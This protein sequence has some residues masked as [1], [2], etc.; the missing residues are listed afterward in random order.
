LETDTIEA[1]A[2]QLAGTLLESRRLAAPVT[3]ESGEIVH[4]IRGALMAHNLNDTVPHVQAVDFAAQFFVAPSATVAVTYGAATHVGNVRDNNEDHFAVIHRFRSQ[5]MLAT[6][7]PRENLHA[8]RDEAYAFVV[9]DGLGGAAGGE[10]ASRLVLE[11][12]WE[13]SAQASSWIMRFSDLSAQQVRKRLDAYA[14]RM[15]ERLIK[16]AESNP[17][18]EGMGTTWT[19]AYVTG[20]D[21]VLAQVG[22]SRAYLLRDGNLRQLTRDHTL[23]QELVD[24]GVDR[25]K[26]ERFRNVVTNTFGGKTTETRV[27]VDHVKLQNGD[28][29]LL[30]TDGLTELVAETKIAEIISRADSPQPAV[31]ALIKAALDAGGNDNITVVLAAFHEVKN[32]ENAGE[33]TSV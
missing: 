9:T 23:A 3:A 10:L 16:L 31:N 17:R 2:A 32:K 4:T 8:F 33:E 27:D 13:L 15:H 12:A 30:C 1:G 20:W 22:D 21:A 19:S 26:T 29:L 24:R 11:E 14:T 7:L 28:R 18:L 25:D 6:N 5:H